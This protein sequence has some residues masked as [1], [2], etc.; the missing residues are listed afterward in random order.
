MVATGNYAAAVGRG[1]T[2]PMCTHVVMCLRL[3]AAARS[4][5]AREREGDGEKLGLYV[6]TWASNSGGHID[7]W[8]VRMSI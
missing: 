5:C 4:V 3:E 8:I 2:L 6:G 7:F 1:F